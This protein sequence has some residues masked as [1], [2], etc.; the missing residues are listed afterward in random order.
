MNQLTNIAAVAFVCLVFLLS[1][2]IWSIRRHRD[3][4]LHIESNSPIDELIPSL[5]ELILG[6]ALDRL[7]P[8]YSQV[9]LRSSIF[10]APR[11]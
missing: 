1:M 2:V 3:P 10:R 7:A 6:V 11:Y 8:T 9:S 4:K 5:A